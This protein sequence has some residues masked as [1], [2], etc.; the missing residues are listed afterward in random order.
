MPFNGHQ[1]ISILFAQEDVK[2]SSRL[3]LSRLCSATFEQLFAVLATSSKFSFQSNFEQNIR[4]EHIS[5]TKMLMISWKTSIHANFLKVYQPFEHV[6]CVTWQRFA[7]LL[8]SSSNIIT[9]NRLKWRTKKAVFVYLLLW[10][11]MDGEKPPLLF[12]FLMTSGLCSPG[13]VCYN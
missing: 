1:F 4:L 13:I 11:E 10:T 9:D 6:T 5:S 8:R 7:G 3:G 12:T 2:H